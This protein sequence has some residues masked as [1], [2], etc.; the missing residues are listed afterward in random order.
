MAERREK[1]CTAAEAAAQ[2]EDGMRIA[3]GGFAV[4]QKP[5]ALVHELIRQRRRNLTLVGAVHSIDADMLIGAGCLKR[6]ETS[7]V[8]LEKFGLAQNYRRAAQAG[9]LEIIHYSEMLSWDRFR[10]D[11]EGW[12]FWPC[13]FLGGNDTAKYNPDVKPY[14]CPV[15][16][17]TA[18]AIPAAQPDVVMLHVYA[19]DKFGNVQMQ[20]RHLLPQYQ[21]LAMARAAGKLIVTAE[22]IIDT[23]ELL[24]KPH[25]TM[26]AG[27]K[28]TCVAHVPRGS[29]PTPTLTE[30][31]MDDLHFARYARESKTPEAFDAYLQKYVY[32]VRDFAEY[33]R[34]VDAERGEK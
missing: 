25:L 5:M 11:R 2:V 27:F 18:F 15:T 29:H 32:G 20:E 14:S 4:Y 19:A 28:T 33:L 6:I 30:T 13:Y 8:G 23:E 21:D 1:L 22:K 10:A 31:L 17:K 3:I 7:Y 26:I 9:A 16:G 12:P 24:E 34:L